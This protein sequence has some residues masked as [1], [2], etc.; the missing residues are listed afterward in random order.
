MFIMNAFHYIFFI[1]TNIFHI[2]IA[3]ELQM[4]NVYMFL[5]WLF[6]HFSKRNIYIYIRIIKS[7]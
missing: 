7:Y 4:K 1:H 2:F 5:S 6:L 3:F